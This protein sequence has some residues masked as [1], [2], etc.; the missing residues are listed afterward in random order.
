[1]T[2]VEDALEAAMKYQMEG[3]PAIIRALLCTFGP[4][5]PQGIYAIAYRLPLEAEAKEAALH[6]HGKCPRTCVRISAQGKLPDWNVTSAGASYFPK[7]AQISAGSLLRLLGFV[8]T[9][10]ETP[11]FLEDDCL[12]TVILSG[13]TKETMI[14]KHLFVYEDTDI[15]KS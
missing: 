12:P 5:E 11:N 8:R 10:G 7:I 6:W 15:F 2:A 14:P 13:D 9:G 4:G 1:L 3:A